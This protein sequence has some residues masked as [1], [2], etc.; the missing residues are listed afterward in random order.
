VLYDPE[1]TVSLPPAITAASGMNA[2]AHCVAAAY[3]PGTDP[4]S[5]LVA[6]EAVRSLAAGLTGSVTNPTDL[7]ARG[8]AL[9]GAYLAGTAFAV[10]GPATHH[11][12]CHILGGAYGLPHAQTHSVVLPYVAALMDSRLGGVAAALGASNAGDGLRDLAERIGAPTSLA[13]IGM[14]ADDLK[15]AID[16]VAEQVD[17]DNPPGLLEAMYEGRWDR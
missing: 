5:R 13:E 9:Y 2:L 16:L 3:L 8:Q 17:L 11:R 10:S 15:E 12:I 7:D 14:R 4:I 1:L 6:L